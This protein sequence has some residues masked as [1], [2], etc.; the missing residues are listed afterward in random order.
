MLI[1]KYFNQLLDKKWGRWTVGI[2][3]LVAL[4]TL[5]VRCE[6]IY[7]GKVVDENGAPIPGVLAVGTWSTVD[8]N[9]AGGNS[10]CLDAKETLTDEKGEFKIPNRWVPLLGFNGDMRIHIYK[11]GYGRVECFWEST[12]RAGDC[13][14]TKMEKEDG[15]WI[16]PLM[17]VKMSRMKYDEGRPPHVSCGRKNG[18][19]LIEYIKANKEY[20]RSR[21]LKE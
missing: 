6:G 3:V 21:G 14:L 7:K 16:F 8:I 20:R 15:R 11:V 1:V 5:P 12:D 4:F 19:P 18:K 13:Y 2:T 9:L 10:R 17:R